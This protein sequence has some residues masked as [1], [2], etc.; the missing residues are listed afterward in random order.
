M[1][2]LVTGGAGFIG[3]NFIDYWLEKYPR[4]SITNLDAMTY[5]ANPLT[6]EHHK[7]RF[8]N[9]R[10]VKGNICNSK[11]VDKLVSK[12][13]AIVHFA[14]ES[15]V[16]RSIE[17]SKVFLET[18][19]LGTH[20]LLNAARMN[21]NKRFHHIS[22]DEVFGSLNLNSKSK[23]YE[24]TTFSPNSPYAASKAASD[25]LV[26]AYY[27]T[28]RLP[29]TITNCSNN[30]GP[31]QFPEKV[32]PLYITRLVK[33]L[34]IPIYGKGKAVRDYIYVIDH[35]RAIESVLQSKKYGEVYCVGG[36]SERN[37]VQVARTILKALNRSPHLIKYTKDRPGH[38]MRYAINYSKITK[39]L[40]WKPIYSFA[41]G[42]ELTID[43]Y[44]INANWYKPILKRAH[45]VAR[46]YLASGQNE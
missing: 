18:N 11:L 8:T 42:I 4:D 36:A 13:D 45:E 1:K 22:T 10:F 37:T 44:K 20:T 46:K 26:N 16:D 28:Y 35:C 7:K 27:K 23:F 40:G 17:G 31:F 39:N 19:V 6:V 21:G 15:H 14:A 32:I 24:N 25:H 5:A 2:L 29:T 41:E 3:S 38:D 34:P 30:Y 9:Y 33:N 43:W 12:V